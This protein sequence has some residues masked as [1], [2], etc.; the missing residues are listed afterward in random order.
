MNN[1][2]SEKLSAIKSFKK[3]DEIHELL[4]ELLPNMGFEDVILTHERGNSPENGKDI[5]C[6]RFDPIE[7]KKRLVCICY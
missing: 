6:S 5:V 4:M 7:D 1:T 2:K 3:E